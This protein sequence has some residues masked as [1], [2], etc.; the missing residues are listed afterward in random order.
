MIIETFPVGPLACNCTILGDEGSG[1]ALLVDPGDDAGEI[2]SRLDRLGLRLEAMISTHAHIDHVAAIRDLQEAA[3]APA[4]IHRD[5]LFLFENL[6]TQAAFLGMKPPRA[7][8][9]DRFLEHGDTVS[10]GTIDIEVFHTP[11][12]TPGSLSFYLN[13]GRGL[14]FSGDTLFLNS[15]GR[16]DLW[17]GSMP[18]LIESIRTRLL[19]LDDETLVVPGHGPRT[20]I[21]RERRENPF[22]R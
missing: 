9:I 11:G 2:L 12:H 20:S 8:R 6:E 10:A 1:K 22:L 5:D 19:C 15:V 3:E 18:D 17:G 21:G 4:S 7:G 16:T 14:L 13:G